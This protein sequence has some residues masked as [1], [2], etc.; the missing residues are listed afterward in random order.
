MVR[1][2]GEGEGRD[3]GGRRMMFRSILRRGTGR[4]R[5]ASLYNKTDSRDT[6]VAIVWLGFR[7]RLSLLE[8]D[9]AAG[10]LAI[11]NLR[12]VVSLYSRI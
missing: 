11:C 10:V 9:C 6:H 8:V 1:I 3:E 5:S 12:Y 7:R 2:A 4:Q